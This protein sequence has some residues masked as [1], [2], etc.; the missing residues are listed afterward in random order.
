MIGA[1]WSDHVWVLPLTV[2]VS[3]AEHIR[4]V[5]I[6]LSS[7]S[8]VYKSL[9]KLVLPLA[10]AEGHLRKNRPCDHT[11]RGCLSCKGFY[12]LHNGHRVLASTD[13]LARRSW[14]AAKAPTWRAL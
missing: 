5:A 6:A 3:W 13:R 9:I 11:G 4:T 10:L 2:S 7:I 1:R 8:I 12:A 14:P